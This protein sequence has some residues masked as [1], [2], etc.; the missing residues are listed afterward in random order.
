MP[1]SAVVRGAAAATSGC[2][3]RVELGDL[4]VQERDA[5]C[6]A[7]QSELRGVDRARSAGRCP[8]A[9]AGR[10]LAL[11]LS[12]LRELSCSRSSLG[13]VRMRSPSCTIAT[14]R[15][16]TALSRA[17][18]SWRID[19]TIPVVCFGVTSRREAECVTGRHLGV[20]RVGL[21]ATPARV[22]V[23]LVDLEHPDALSDE[24]ARQAGRVGAGRLHADPVDHAE[25]REPSPA[26]RGS[27]QPTPRTTRFPAAPRGR[28]AP[29][30]DG[31]RRASRRRR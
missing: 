22:R 3:L 11:P 20:D 18:R 2:E 6:E 7:A 27:R 24:M 31:Y 16:F 12:V 10:A 13:A 30:R 26:A 9:A 8:G 14:D 17:T 5:S 29:R 19:S 15:D 28:R 25:R 4:V 1:S 21:P 23:R